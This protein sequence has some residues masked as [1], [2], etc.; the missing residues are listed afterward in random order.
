MP[1]NIQGNILITEDGQ[2]CL[3]EFGITGSFQRFNY[4]FYE[5]ETLRYMA[6]ESFLFPHFPDT[7]TTGPLKESDV[8]SLALTSFT[9]CSSVA[10]HLAVWC[11]LPLTIRSLRGCCRMTAAT[12]TGSPGM[13]GTVDGHHA[14]RTQ[15]R[16]NGCMTPFGM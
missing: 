9:V 10:N 8:Y 14:Q 12:V 13:S 2:P 11:N 4:Y 5:L 1:E 3:G 15:V 7:K 6:P 16:P